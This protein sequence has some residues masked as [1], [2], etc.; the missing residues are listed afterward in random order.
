MLKS[1]DKKTKLSLRSA[2]YFSTRRNWIAGLMNLNDKSVKIAGKPWK[3]WFKTTAHS[4]L[5]M[6][7]WNV[8]FILFVFCL[9][10]LCFL[11]CFILFCFSFVCL[12]V[13]PKVRRRVGKLKGKMK[14]ENSEEEQEVHMTPECRTTLQKALYF[15]PVG[16]SWMLL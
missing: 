12:F 15:L 2:C 11:F 9:F 1:K 14:T 7:F 5:S 4:I 13:L 6:H 10:I 16:H 8:W 3:Y